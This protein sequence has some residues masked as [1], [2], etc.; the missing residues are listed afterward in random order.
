MR[1]FLVLILLAWAVPAGAQTTLAERLGYDA[2]DKLLIVHA[3]DIG[4]AHSV[5]RATFDA[6]A[7]GLVNSASIMVP[8][9]WLPEVARYMAEHPDADLGLHL[10][11]TSEWQDFKWGGVLSKAQTPGLYREDGYYY[12]G[13]ME[14]AMGATA[15]EVEAEIRA[16]VEQALRMGIQPTHLDSHMGTLFATPAFFDAYLRVGRAYKLP[17][18]IPGNMIGMRGQEFADLLTP[19]DIV[20]DYLY[21]ISESVKKDD[22]ESYY[23]GVVENLQPGVSQII[24]HLAYDDAEMQGVTINHPDFGA[25]WRQRD[26]DY[27]TSEAFR[28][29]LEAHDVKL[30]TWREIGQLIK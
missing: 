28:S 11:L 2:D 30:I 7:T 3:D 6:M 26:F 4:V 25:A 18:L 19:E 10:T 27:F 20:I 22:W 16:Q 24:I 15:E 13:V 23:A 1:F 12:P 5:N 21:M 9:P 17:V 14:V 8:C 29:L